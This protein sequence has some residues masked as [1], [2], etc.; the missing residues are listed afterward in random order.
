MPAGGLEHDERRRERGQTLD[1]R[2]HV[3]VVIVDGG[4]LAGGA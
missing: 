4:A 3:L 2:R 1:Q